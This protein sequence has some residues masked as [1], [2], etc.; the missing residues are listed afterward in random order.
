MIRKIG[1]VV[2]TTYTFAVRTR[3]ALSC[4][5]AARTTNHEAIPDLAA[6]PERRFF[7]YVEFLYV[8]SS[9]MYV[10][11]LYNCS[12]RTNPMVRVSPS[13][14]N[15]VALIDAR[16]REG[17]HRLF[18]Y[19]PKHVLP[20]AEKVPGYLFQDRQ[21]VPATSEVPR[22][23]GNWT[24]QTRRL[25]DKGMGYLNFIQWAEE[26]EI[27]VYVPQSF[28]ELIRNK[29][30]TYK[31]VRAYHDSLHP[32]CEPYRQSPRQLQYFIDNGL[33]FIKPR[34]GSK[35]N[36]IITMRRGPDGLAIRYYSDGR[37]KDYTASS[38][39]EAASFVRKLT[40]GSR[41]YIIQQGV[42]TLRHRGS[43]FDVRV[44]MVNDGS[45]WH[46][47][48]ETRLSRK[49][50]DLSNV[51]QGG[52]SVVT[53][54]FLFHLLGHED[55]LLTLQDLKSE[56]FGLAKY[57]ERLHP[58]DIMEI[59]FDFVVDRNRQLRLVEV[60]TKPGLASIGFLTTIYDLGPEE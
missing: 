1:R 29:H 12:R 8:D 24:Y 21:F 42:E 26:H 3:Y 4:P 30:E 17:G 31:L 10:G 55:A 41:R 57:L 6:V 56:S 15:R 46:W 18:F 20:D 28:S 58:G 7:M 54:E 45:A 32:Y 53:E 34:A 27:G 2:W 47:I 33:T 43:V 49:G 19:S 11:F 39:A 50:S 60:N 52:E 48:H 44:L 22:V 40:R 9:F 35:G 37:R 25:L 59:A 38:H 16:L 36:R 5:R 13:L 51:S 14:L 23:N